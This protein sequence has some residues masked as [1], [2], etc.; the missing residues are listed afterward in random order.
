MAAS[1]NI[2]SANIASA[3]PWYSELI[4]DDSILARLFTVD[5]AG[6]LA[7]IAVSLVVGLML[8]GIVLTIVKRLANKRLDSRSGGLVVKIVQYLGLAFVAINVLDAADVDLSPL[9]GAAGIAGIA[10]GFAAQTSVSNFI[11]GFFLMSEKTF[12]EGDVVSVDATTGIVYSIDTLSVKLRTFDNQLVRIPNETLI[13]ST[14][15]NITRFSVRRLNIRLTI[16]YGS[17]LERAKEI[18]YDVALSTEG[19]LRKP[20]PIFMVQ[21]LGKDGVELLFGIW[22]AKE[23]WVQANNAAYHAVLSRFK[24]EGLEF[25]HPTMTIY[26]KR[27]D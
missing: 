13:K 23:D 3:A 2:A 24:A 21:G 17:D 25:A 22:I 6:R 7:R 4:P 16:T 14:V 20:E 27:E 15:T 11:S 9:L 10:L 1:A 8:V 5:M 18:L 19:V 26:P 12:A